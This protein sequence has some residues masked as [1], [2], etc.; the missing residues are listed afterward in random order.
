MDFCCLDLHARF[1]II[2]V[3]YLPR[4]NRRAHQITPG[5]AVTEDV[6]FVQINLLIN[7]FNS[8]GI[9]FD[10]ADFLLTVDY[11]E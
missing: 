2:H 10:S 9:L 4:F 6:F 3:Y 11:Y 8:F 5:Q 1:K 7:Y